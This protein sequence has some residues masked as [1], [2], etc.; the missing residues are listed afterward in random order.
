MERS[1]VYSLLFGDECLLLLCCC[2]FL[3]LLLL[4]VAAAGFRFSSVSCCCFCLGPPRERERQTERDRER[5]TDRERQRETERETERERERQRER[6]RE[7]YRRIGFNIGHYTTSLFLVWLFFFICLRRCSGRERRRRETSISA[8]ESALVV[9]AD[10]LTPSSQSIR[11]SLVSFI[12]Y[13][14][15]SAVSLSQSHV[16]CL[17]LC[18]LSLCL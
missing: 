6:Y 3:L 16:C 17:S 18:L 4:L 12:C 5:E 8:W 7:R 1:R 14:S 11:Y 2:C 15:T 13:L 10:C 9:A